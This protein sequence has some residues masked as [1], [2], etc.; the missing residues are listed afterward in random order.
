M[1]G[2]KQTARTIKCKK[3]AFR[4][5]R[6]ARIFSRDLLRAKQKNSAENKNSKAKL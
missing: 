5:S 3:A 1:S 6:L 4:D 2:T